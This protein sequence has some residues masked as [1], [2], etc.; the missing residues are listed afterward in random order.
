MFTTSTFFTNTHTDTHGDGI[1]DS[2]CT[3]QE[4]MLLYNV[5]KST[6]V[7]NYKQAKIPLPHKLNIAQWRSYLRNYHDVQVFE[8]LE[9]EWPMDYIPSQLLMRADQNHQ[10]ARAYP[11]HVKTYLD[12]E[13]RCGALMGPCNSAGLQISPLMSREKRNSQSRRIIM[14]LSWPPG[15]SV[16]D[17]IPK[18]T[19]LDEP[20]KLTLPTVDDVVNLIREH[21]QGCYLY[22]QDLERAYRQLRSDPLDWPLLGL[23]WDNKYY[24][25][26]AVPFGIRNG[27][28]ACQRTTNAICFIHRLDN[29]VSRCYIDDFLGVASTLSV[30]ESGFNR[31][32]DIL[33]ELGVSEACEKSSPPTRHLTWIGIEFDTEAMVMRIPPRPD[34]RNIDISA[35]M[36]TSATNH[37]TSI[38]KV[39]GKL[40]YIS[41]CVHPARLFVSRLLAT[42]RATPRQGFITLDEEFKRDVAWFATF[43][44]KYNGIHFIDSS[45]DDMQIEV[46]SCMTGCGGIHGDEYY[47]VEFPVSITAQKRPICHLEMLN[48]LVAVKL[49]STKN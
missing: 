3:L 13:L 16:N 48:I 39:V 24:F 27:A 20:F 15:A 26:V 31:L 19:Y 33:Q 5:V 2:N 8:F 47:H 40:F 38:A 23:E 12:K 6:G 45:I 34:I 43:L 22:S 35:R 1:S 42:L 30:A 29:Y 41:Q 37:E 44:P 25:D 28:M 21:G 36:V 17:G 9:Y 46:D 49:W 4:H 11:Q 7:P 32:R 10:S 14:D 18:D